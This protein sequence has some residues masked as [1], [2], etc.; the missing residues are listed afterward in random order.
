MEDPHYSDMEAHADNDL[1]ITHSGSNGNINNKTG[2]L[3]IRTLGSGDDIFI[4]AKIP[5]FKKKIYPILENSNNEIVWIP[6][7]FDKNSSLQANDK[8]LIKWEE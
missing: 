6:G 4:D 1:E 2:D 3:V 7:L 5:L 8:I